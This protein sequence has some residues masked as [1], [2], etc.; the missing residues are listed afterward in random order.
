MRWPLPLATARSSLPSPLKSAAIGLTSRFGLLPP[1]VKVA[2]VP[3]PPLP[4]PKRTA[5]LSLSCVGHGQI[6]FAVAVEVG[7]CTYARAR[8]RRCCKWRRFRNP[9]LPLPKRIP[10]V[11][12]S[13]L[14]STARSRLPSPL[15]S[16]ASHAHRESVPPVLIGAGQRE[17]ADSR[18]PAGFPRRCW[19][20]RSWLWRHPPCRRG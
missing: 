10:T 5:T 12:W 19:R 8:R 18:C 20:C 4:L 3:K 14:L 11:P 6:E 2:A 13:L 17:S 7:Q 15:K 16:P 1:V 9:P